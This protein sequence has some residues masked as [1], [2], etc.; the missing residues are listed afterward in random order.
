M[1]APFSA[2]PLSPQAYRTDVLTG[3][4]PHHETRLMQ[5]P[6]PSQPPERPD[7]TGPRRPAPSSP[8]RE[9]P[10]YHAD[11]SPT[12][13]K[14]PAAG[15]SGS[16]ARRVELVAGPADGAL[17]APAPVPLPRPGERVD[18]F[19]LEQAIGVGGMGAVFRA[20]D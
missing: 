17:M 12:I 5:D 16:S 18:V 6:D 15:S 1:H 7:A 10:V 19:E 9:E 20:L 14:A 13:R 2:R 11:D 3:F 4:S 8:R